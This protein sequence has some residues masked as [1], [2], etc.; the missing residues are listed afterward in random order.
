VGIRDGGDI[1]VWFIGKYNGGWYWMALIISFGVVI[2]LGIVAIILALRM[3]KKSKNFLNEWGG[4]GCT[5]DI[6]KSWGK[7]IIWAYGDKYIGKI[8]CISAGSKVG[9][10]YHIIGNK[11]IYVISGRMSL[12]LDYNGESRTII[13]GDDSSIRNMEIP[14]EVVHRIEAL[15]DCQIMEI[16]ASELNDVVRLEDV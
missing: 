15:T 3:S 13:L 9:G 10:R 8:L 12:D 1:V 2:L 16:S 5:V 7:E 14:K 6:P 4:L 11:N